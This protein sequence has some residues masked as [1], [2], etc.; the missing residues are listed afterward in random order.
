LK[1][2]VVPNYKS[3][4]K[5]IGEFVEMTNKPI[6]KNFKDLEKFLLQEDTIKD[7][8][9]GKLVKN[10]MLD[11]KTKAFMECVD[12]LHEALKE[13]IL[14]NLRSN[15]LLNVENESYLNQAIEFSRL[16]KLDIYNINK[17]KYAEFTYDFV[18]AAESGYQ[19]EPSKMKIEKT[20]FKL[21]H[22]DKTLDY[23]KKRVDSFSK[24]NIYKI[25]K[26]FQRTNME[27]MS[28]KVYKSNI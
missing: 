8:A 3:L 7:Y 9:A 20:K 21:L 19:V 28:R 26:M 16:R 11:C 13:S 2:E 23:I 15:N 18:R 12:D 4:T 14:I 1:E 17:V 5:L 25:G 22:D 24:D 27:V 10:E 6:Y